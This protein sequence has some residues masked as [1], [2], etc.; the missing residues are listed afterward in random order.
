MFKSPPTF[1]SE[2]NVIFSVIKKNVVIIYRLVNDGTMEYDHDADGTHQELASC[3]TRLRNRDFKTY[4]RISYKANTLK[5]ELDVQGKNEWETCFFVPDVYL[6][7]GFHFGISAATGDLADNHDIIWITTADPSPLTPEEETRV[8][9]LEAKGLLEGR[10]L[11]ASKFEDASK[12]HLPFA[13]FHEKER[14]KN[15]NHAVLLWLRWMR[16]KGLGGGC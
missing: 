10:D 14:G 2:K 15:R 12:K 11:G 8:K 7:A 3:S 4:S 5:V 1:Y 9:E 13:R 6:P 16:R